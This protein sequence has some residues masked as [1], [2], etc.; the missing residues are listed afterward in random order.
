[1][2][3]HSR[4]HCISL[5]LHCFVSAKHSLLSLK[6]AMSKLLLRKVT[7][8]SH[9]L[10]L[11]RSNHNHLPATAAL[12][13]EASTPVHH[14]PSLKR[15]R[16][17]AAT[18][19]LHSY[20]NFQCFDNLNDIFQEIEIVDGG[21]FFPTIEWSTSSDEGADWERKETQQ[22]CQVS[23]PQASPNR[24]LQLLR[25]PTVFHRLHEFET[26]AN[27]CSM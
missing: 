3:P 18:A 17:D 15:Q 14:T 27:A 21:S 20:A 5:H 2:S 25:S 23:P 4:R 8:N 16:T 19:S 22:H 10:S 24:K 7:M 26:R 12:E 11:K 13:K 6:A 1:M 9:L